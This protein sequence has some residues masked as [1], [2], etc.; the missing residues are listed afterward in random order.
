[1]SENLFR[2]KARQAYNNRLNGQV[3]IA[4]NPGHW[5]LAGLLLAMVLVIL[6]FFL[7]AE[8]TP[9]SKAAGKLVPEE[10]MVKVYSSGSGVV[11]ELHVEEGDVVKA[12]EPL[13]T[14]SFQSSTLE[15]QQWG[16]TWLQESQGLLDSLEQDIADIRHSAKLNRDSIESRRQLIQLEEQQ[17]NNDLVS[18]ERQIKLAKERLERNKRLNREGFSSDEQVLREQE[19]LANLQT[20]I[21]NTRLKLQANQT[22]YKALE[23]ELKQAEQE[24]NRMISQLQRE[25]TAVRQ[26]R[27]ERQSQLEQTIAAPKSGK[28][29][30]LLAEVGSRVS[31]QAPVMTL[32]PLW[33]MMQAEVY[34]PA[35]AIGFI[36][37]GQRV[38]LKF[39][40]FPYQRYG[41]YGGRVKYIS[42]STVAPGD[43]S[44]TLGFNQPVYR[45]KIELKNQNIAV[46]DGVFPMM[47]GMAVEM[48]LIGE[49][50]PFLEWL[51][52]P[53]QDVSER[54]Q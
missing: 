16:E 43:L 33:S 48:D 11:E 32:L 25:A 39:P 31:P 38:E 9:K 14:V 50:I 13:M 7:L 21:A 34:I 41:T 40:S 5:W 36:H 28:V 27:I 24:R 30:T 45:M 54:F 17:L 23:S 12:G 26:Q 49:P 44:S 15:G 19:S 3:R 46:R 2:Q 6:V 20:T 42:Q 10:G 1:M 22:E 29:T 18:L 8:Y 51:M 4:T 47:A 53:I 52:K 35:S 37:L